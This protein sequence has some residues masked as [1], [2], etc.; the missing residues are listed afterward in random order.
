MMGM[1]RV[2]GYKDQGRKRMGRT[3]RG[4]VSYSVCMKMP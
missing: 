3:V 1:M 2:E 4:R